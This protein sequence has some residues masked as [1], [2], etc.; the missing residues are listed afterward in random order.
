MNEIA[1]IATMVV[2]PIVAAFI[3]KP[4]LSRKPADVPIKRQV[5]VD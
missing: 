3:R 2:N 5:Q 1:A 4:P